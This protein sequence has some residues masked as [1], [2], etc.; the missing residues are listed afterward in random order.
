[1]KK[2]WFILVMCSL[3]L[4]G[5]DVT[6]SIGMVLKEI[7]A[8]KEMKSFYISQ[9][10]VTQAQWMKIMGT[11]P[12]FFQSKTENLPV[13][14]IDLKSALEFIKRLK[15]KEN[16]GAYRLLTADEFKY[17]TQGMC[18]S[19]NIANASNFS[20]FHDYDCVENSIVYVQM[21]PNSVKS[22]Q[23]NKFGVFDMLGNVNELIYTCQGDK[24][25]P[26]VMGG[27]WAYKSMWDISQYDTLMTPGQYFE[28]LYIS[29]V[30]QG[31]NQKALIDLGF[32]IVK[33]K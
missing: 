14:S 24:C 16:T 33:S 18:E 3:S 30:N 26:S 27:S 13:D 8:S 25:N 20:Q 17:L 32:H 11:N 12:S 2:I 28:R 5:A 9:T 29:Q 6:N 10:E 22:K 1:M 7:P 21:T 4:L 19:P 31:F 15:L 23:A